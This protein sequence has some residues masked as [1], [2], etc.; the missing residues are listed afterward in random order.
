MLR[1]LMFL[2]SVKDPD[3]GYIVAH[4]NGMDGTWNCS[5]TDGPLGP[6]CVLPRPDGWLSTCGW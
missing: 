5:R 3:G 1:E 4:G 6:P 2:C